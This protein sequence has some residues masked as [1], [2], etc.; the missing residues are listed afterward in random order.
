VE[1]R[2]LRN[3]ELNILYSLPYIIRVIKSRRINWGREHA[4]VMRERRGAYR[5]LVGNPEG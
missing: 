3:E 2:I 5:I 4:A 1:W